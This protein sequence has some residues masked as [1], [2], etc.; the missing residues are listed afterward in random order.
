MDAKSALFRNIQN[1]ANRATNLLNQ[2]QTDTYNNGITSIADERFDNSLNTVVK[3]INKNCNIISSAT[4]YQE[5]LRNTILAFNKF[6]LAYP[7]TYLSRGIPYVFFT[8]PDLNLYD[9]PGTRLTSSAN[10]DPIISGLHNSDPFLLQTLTKAFNTHHD[11]NPFL[12][13]MALSFDLSDESIETLATG[14]TFTGWRVK[15]GRH[16][17]AYKSSG[18]FSVSYQD[19]HKLQVY[20]LHKAWVEYISKVYRG[21]LESKRKYIQSRRLDYACSAYYFVCAPDGETILYWSKYV[22][23]FPSTVPTGTLAW[24]KGGFIGNLDSS[25]TYEY[26]WKSDME[27][28]IIRDFNVNS[29]IDDDEET[30]GISHSPSYDNDLVGAGYAF[31]KAPFIRIE[32]NSDGQFV[33]RLKFKKMT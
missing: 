28:P 26:S 3:D 13:N 10:S 29:K 11:F 22:G 24:N 12:S 4:A 32:T 1:M 16:N 14:D 25:I 17:I 19:T 2:S 8:R 6:K 7:D 18:Q 33:F 5:T 31:A 27:L 9:I 30:T 20:K 23:V 15:Y 21:E